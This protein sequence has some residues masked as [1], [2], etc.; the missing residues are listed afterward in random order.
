MIRNGRIY[1]DDHNACI[2]SNITSN[3]RHP[4]LLSIIRHLS[5][6]P[7]SILPIIITVITIII[8]SSPS[9]INHQHR[10]RHHNHHQPAQTVQPIRRG[11]KFLLGTLEGVLIRQD[12][13]HASTVE[14]WIH[15]LP[16]RVRDPQLPLDRRLFIPLIIHLCDNHLLSKASG[17]IHGLPEETRKK[18]R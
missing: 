15:L 10:H 17:D 18:Q 14:Q 7:S 8:S 11:S 3:T 5:I 12:G 13:E 4:S 2:Q 16:S 1:Y 9:I 6:L